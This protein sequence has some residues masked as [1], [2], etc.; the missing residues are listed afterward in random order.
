MRAWW[1]IGLLSLILA[2]PV[3]AQPAW[4]AA[5]PTVKATPLLWTVHGPKGTAYLLGSVHALPKNVDWKTPKIL[6]AAKRADSFV[7]EI[8]MDKESL[9]E[10]A[11]VIGRKAYL[12]LTLSL[13]SY[14]D[15]QM[16]TDYRH[17]VENTGVNPEAVVYMRPWMAAET[18]ND[19]MSGKMPI[20]AAEGVDNKIYEMAEKR[21]VKDIRA[22]ETADLQIQ[23]LKG[24]ATP[25]NELSLLRTALHE[26]STR[27]MTQFDKLL[28]G[29]E[30]GDAKAIFAFGPGLMTTEERTRL[31][32][33]R[34]QRWIPQI[35][36]MLRQKK[37]FFI[38]VGAAHLVGP[39]GVPNLLRTA[40]YKV[41]GP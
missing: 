3:L 26:A 32:D 12:P 35:E 41:D 40:G 13:P 25:A 9:G 2:Q 27:P 1:K 5:A 30:M 28:A 24:A 18:F 33:N 34:N 10:A 8:P 19:A 14:F 36:A 7:F 22:F 37:V 11:K 20:F 6:A 29:W 4:A 17:A 16:R 31:L 38:T 39:H 15:S 21:G 23:A